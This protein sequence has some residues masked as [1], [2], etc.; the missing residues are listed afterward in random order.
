MLP[1]CCQKVFMFSYLVWNKSVW[2]CLLFQFSNVST[3]TSTVLVGFG[4][5]KNTRAWLHHHSV[6]LYQTHYIITCIVEPCSVKIIVHLIK[7]FKTREHRHKNYLYKHFKTRDHRHKN[8]LYKHLKTR[9]H[10]HKNY[11]YKHFKTREH[12]HKDYLYK[13]FKTREHQHKNYLYKLNS[14]VS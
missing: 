10:R 8:Y 9:E 13:H 7:H 2:K 1:T 4:L 11:L 6:Y 12:R 3:H 5:K 14:L